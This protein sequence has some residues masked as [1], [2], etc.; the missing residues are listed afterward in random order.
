MGGGHS[1]VNIQDS[2]NRIVT[3]NVNSSLQT[4]NQT[5]IVLQQLRLDCN[6]L[7]RTVGKAYADCIERWKDDPSR[8]AL[9]SAHLERMRDCRVANVSLDQAIKVN[10]N[11]EQFQALDVSL[12]QNLQNRIQ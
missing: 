10:L 1:A 8:R 12:Q 7:A 3:A 11:A 4:L 9:C 6:E 5:D 2:L